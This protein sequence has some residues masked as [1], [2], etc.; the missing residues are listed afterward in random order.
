LNRYLGDINGI[1]ESQDW[2]V[3]PGSRPKCEEPTVLTTQSSQLQLYDK[4]LLKPIAGRTLAIAASTDGNFVRVGSALYAKQNS[5]RHTLLDLGEHRIDYIEEM[6]SSGRWL[7]IAHRRN[8]RET[9]LLKDPPVNPVDVSE[10]STVSDTSNS[11]DESDSSSNDGV[12]EEEEPTKITHD[13]DEQAKV[14]S[15]TSDNDGFESDSMAT[16]Q[17]CS[18]ADSYSEASTVDAKDEI[19][20]QSD[21]R[22]SEIG[23]NPLGSD[24]SDVSSSLDYELWSSDDDDD[25][26]NEFIRTSYN[27]SIENELM[28]KLANETFQEDNFSDYASNTS[29][30][31]ES[32]NLEIRSNISQWSD[33]ESDSALEENNLAAFQKLLQDDTDEKADAREYETKS[34][35]KAKEFCQLTIFDASD[36][37]KPLTHV[38]SFKSHARGCLF[39][40]P[41]IFHPFRKL[42][43][44][45]TGGSE[46]L[47]ANFAQRK[48]YFR[49][50]L[51]AGE[52]NT[53]HISVQGRFSVDGKFLHLACL[54]GKVDADANSEIVKAA[55]V[56]VRFR[57]RVF[58][59][60][61]S[62]GKPERSPP[63]LIYRATTPLDVPGIVRR[64]LQVSPLP[65][66]LT[67]TDTHV[68]AAHSAQILRVIRVPLFEEIEKLENSMFRTADSSLCKPFGASGSES[69]A[70]LKTVAFQNS[71]L[72][73]LPN[74][75]SNRRI[76]FFP[77]TMS[78]QKPSQPS[79]MKTKK[80]KGAKEP[81]VAT[82]LISSE[83]T[84][85]AWIEH[86]FGA[87][88]AYSGPPQVIYLTASDIG[89]WEQMPTNSI[90]SRQEI[91]EAKKWKCGKL[92]GKC[93][94]FD[95]SEDCDIVPYFQF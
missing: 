79:Q 12:L 44:W 58:T 21:A 52:P 62:Q 20:Y 63:R 17:L 43:V 50:Y 31:E 91:E 46:I 81:I 30:E 61:L 67:W 48:T 49:R 69:K 80:K 72:L 84:S 94:E 10:S 59:Y 86:H 74:S 70:E 8:V 51:G 13:I 26:E 90:F 11:S 4:H 2:R 25:S 3:I 7:A 41:P 29:E 64:K 89:E 6:E 66:T 71:K 42:V 24:G 40:S 15:I 36:T 95:K 45:P 9:D 92:E 88:L 32:E 53:C 68:F 56:G 83:S 87:S 60:R 65:Y 22:S 78:P 82:V 37:T 38:F 27:R 35:P 77:T 23:L 33:G 16:S 93:E 5:G 47:F 54:D 85:T 14:D 39:N 55:G 34:K 73:F 76:H 1:Y 28:R 75:A 18:A 19:D 57:L